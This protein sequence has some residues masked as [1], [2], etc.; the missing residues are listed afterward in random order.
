ML[1]NNYINNITPKKTIIPEPTQGDTLEHI[2]EEEEEE[3]EKITR[4][5]FLARTGLMVG[6]VPFIVLSRGIVFA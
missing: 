6:A 2:H 4:S 5:Q 1:I 3:K